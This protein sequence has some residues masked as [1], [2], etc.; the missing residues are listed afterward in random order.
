[1]YKLQVP[2]DLAVDG[3]DQRGLTR[4]LVPHM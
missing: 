2:I 4:T 1:L 3:I